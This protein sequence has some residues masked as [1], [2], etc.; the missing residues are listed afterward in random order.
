[1]VFILLN[2]RLSHL[3]HRVC[4]YFHEGNILYKTNNGQ[5][6]KTNICT[7]NLTNACTKNSYERIHIHWWGVE[8]VIKQQFVLR[9]DR[10]CQYIKNLEVEYG[11]DQTLVKEQFVQRSDHLCYDTENLTKE[12]GGQWP[13]V[14]ILTNI[15][16]ICKSS[17]NS[18][19]LPNIWL[20]VHIF[21]L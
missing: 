18:A 10:F 5:F 19:I 13:Y 3:N 6:S 7:N 20:F 9:P 16:C 21:C 2:P 15:C 11:G 1:M 14:Y 12:Y 8:K 17:D 4:V